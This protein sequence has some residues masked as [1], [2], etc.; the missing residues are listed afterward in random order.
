LSVVG[1]EIATTRIAVVDPQAIFSFD[2]DDGE[3]EIAFFFAEWATGSPIAPTCAATTAREESETPGID[4]DQ[5]G[6]R[7]RRSASDAVVTQP[8]LLIAPALECCNYRAEI[9]G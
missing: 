2:S 4:P 1:L 8:A 9:E 3:R 7:R 6:H 5:M